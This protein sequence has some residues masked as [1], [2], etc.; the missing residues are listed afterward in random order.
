MRSKSYAAVT[1]SGKIIASI[2]S[3]YPVDFDTTNLQGDFV[4]IPGA[5]RD[6]LRVYYDHASATFV[7]M[8]ASPGEYYEFSYDKK[9]WVFSAAAAWGNIRAE[10]DRLIGKT[11]W[12]ILADVNQSS[13]ERRAWLVYRQALR[14]I[15]LQADPLNIAWPVPPT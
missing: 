13:E 7:D 14:D 15:T 8:P 2:W 10:R 4:V 5:P 6:V 11:D 12:R 3:T 9:A 1:P